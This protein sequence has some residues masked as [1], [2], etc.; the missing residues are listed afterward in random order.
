MRYVLDSSVAYKWVVPEP[1]SDKAIRL[2]EDFLKGIH[3][4]IAPDF[5]V[6]ELAH[7]LTRAERIKPVLLN[8]GQAEIV[9]L[10]VMTTPPLLFPSQAIGQRAIQI[11]SAA[12]IGSYDCAYRCA[13][14]TR[15]MRVG[16]RRFQAGQEPPEQIPF[17]QA[18]RIIPLRHVSGHL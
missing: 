18:S 15:A 7:A 1:D 2:R 8:A 17:H 3:T 11:S 6:M 10:D 12:Q 4:L 14:R 9:W 5:F 16:D 13:C